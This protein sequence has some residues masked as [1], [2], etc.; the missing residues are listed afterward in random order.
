[1]NVLT[2]LKPKTIQ[3]FK[4]LYSRNSIQNIPEDYLYFCQNC[5]FPGQNLVGIREGLVSLATAGTLASGEFV[6]SAFGYSILIYGYEATDFLVLTNQG[7][8]IDTKGPTVL[9]TFTGSPMPDDISCINLYGRVFISL[10]SYGNG[11]Y[12]GVIYYYDGTLFLPIAGAGPITAPTLSTTGAGNTSAGTYTVAYS[13]QYQYGYISPPGP[14]ANITVP[15]GTDILISS[16][17]SSYPA[18]VIG[19]VIEMTIAD[20]SELFFIPVSALVTTTTYDWTGSDTEL[21]ASA[22]YLFNI[23]TSVNCA[24]ALKFYHGRMVIV[25][26]SGEEQLVLFSNQN[27]P[28]TFDQVNG[29]VTLPIDFAA[30]NPNTGLIIN[31]TFY[32]IK[33]NQTFATQDNASYPATWNVTAI[34]AAMG[35]WDTGVSSFGSAYVDIF[36]SSLVCNPRGLM[37]FTG[38]YQDTPLSFNIEALW[39]SINPKLFYLV[40]ISHDIW[41]KRV[42]IAAP[43]S[44][45]STNNFIFMMDYKEGLTPSK[46]KWSTWVFGAHTNITRLFTG[47]YVIF[48]SGAQ[49]IAQNPVFVFGDSNEILTL[50]TA[51]TQDEGITSITQEVDT[52]AISVGPGVNTYLMAELNILFNQNLI[53]QA[54]NLDRTVNYSISGYSNVPITPLT[55]AAFTTFVVNQIIFDGSNYQLVIIGGTSGPT[56]PIWDHSGSTTYDGQYIS[57]GGVTYQDLGTLITLPLV[58]AGQEFY[59]PLNITTE[60]LMLKFANDNTQSA[61]NFTLNRIDLFSVPAWN[62][63]PVIPT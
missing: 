62:M 23:L 10:K 26:L 52:A 55:W 57:Y 58:Y 45:F 35:G 15:G 41:N 60:K 32:I 12:N 56:L 4:G 2:G 30:L 25:G 13:Y 1:M 48:G 44:G 63:R 34:D 22:D 7:R 46:V 29:I 27:S 24:S 61:S 54:F 38:S 40:Q 5:Q 33:P 6:I 8:L 20:G 59:V 39:L 36:D 28:E 37:L 49:N 11:W 18:G 31:D 51:N 47:V 42:Y 50:T 53:L 9:G 43:G 19:V 17:P 3:G 14:T 21:T 16:L